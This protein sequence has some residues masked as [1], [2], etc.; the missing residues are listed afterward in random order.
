MVLVPRA[1][2]DEIGVILMTVATITKYFPYLY[3]DRE[4]PFFPRRVGYTVF[5]SSGPS[6]SFRREITF[7][8]AAV[9]SVIEYAIYWDF[10]I[11][12]L[13]DL[14]HVWVFVGWDGAVADCECSFHGKYL[15]GLLDQGGNL[16]DQTHVRLFSQPGKHAFSPLAQMFQLLPDFWD[17]TTVNVGRDG[18]C[19]T[20][21][22]ARGRYRTNPEI[23][24]KIR[25]YMQIYRFRPMLKYQKYVPPPE[26]FAPWPVLDREIPEMVNQK[27]GEILALKAIINKNK[28]VTAL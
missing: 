20:E 21:N 15:K 25:E 11:T 3:F 7:K 12:H 2:R 26:L 19:V 4:E 18:L 17:A 9:K 23:D 28:E 13:Y 27:L 5:D 14:E 16:E 22:I 6:P 10:D 24:G 8:T 1:T